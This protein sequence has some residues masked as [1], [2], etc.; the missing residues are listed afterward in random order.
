MEEGIAFCSFRE[1]MQ[2]ENHEDREEHEEKNILNLRDLRVL[3]GEIKNLHKPDRY[4]CWD[5]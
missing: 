5:L 4:G 3:R 1:L 2:Q